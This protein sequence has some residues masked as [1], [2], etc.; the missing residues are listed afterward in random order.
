MLSR[1]AKPR[2]FLSVA[3]LRIRVAKECGHARRRE[4]LGIRADADFWAGV[5]ETGAW[6]AGESAAGH[7]PKGA[8]RAASPVE[9]KTAKTASAARALG[10]R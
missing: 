9:W 3:L 8:G 6:V 2:P 10:R 7:D 1:N 5:G 4:G